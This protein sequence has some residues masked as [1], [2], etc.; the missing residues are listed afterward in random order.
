MTFNEFAYFAYIVLA[1]ITAMVLAG[2]AVFVWPHRRMA[3]VPYLLASIVL[4]ILSAISNTIEL[5]AA[6]P[7]GTL[8][9]S[10]VTYTF[11]ALFPPT[12]FL[13]TLE[14]VRPRLY[15]WLH[16]K[17]PL[18]YLIPSI[19]V[20]LAYWPESGLLWRGYEMNSYYGLLAIDVQGYGP[21]FW[22]H[23]AYAY[24]ITLFGWGLLAHDYFRRRN[25]PHRSSRLILGGS[26]FALVANFLYLLRLLP[27]TKDYTIIFSGISLL[28]ISLGLMRERIFSLRPLAALTIADNLQDGILL[29]DEHEVIIDANQAAADIL[30]LTAEDMLGQEAQAIVGHCEANG[31]IREVLFHADSDT[32][33]H[34]EVQ[35]LPVTSR[36]GDRIGSVIVL[37]D[38]STRK[39]YEQMLIAHVERINNLYNASAALLRNTDLDDVLHVMVQKARY[40][41]KD[42]QRT[43]WYPLLNSL[44]QTEI[45]SP[46]G[47]EVP[48]LN[49]SHA[50]SNQ[51]LPARWIEGHDRT[52]YLQPIQ[53]SS[54]VFGVLAFEWPPDHSLTPED[55]KIIDSYAITAAAAL[56][57]ALYHTAI[58]QAELTDP[59]TGVLNR[60]GLYQLAQKRVFETLGQEYALLH[61]DLDNLGRINQLYGRAAGDLTLKTVGDIIQKSLRSGDIVSRYG[62]DDFLIILPRQDLD[63]ARRIANRLQAQVTQTRINHQGST[64][65]ISV[66]IGITPVA[67]NESIEAALERSVQ[68]LRRAKQQGRNRIIVAK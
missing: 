4:L 36:S 3:G 43:I 21:W 55:R 60:Q 56:Q 20:I 10:H 50:E 68:A 62:D 13:F 37:H 49:L 46:A 28:L 42:C 53:T 1:P 51:P 26:L 11:I 38:V 33:L 57:N 15:H 31:E 67:A 23:A 45:A 29:L 6:T 19:T 35:C 7:T 17:Y 25:T 64:F 39:A 27:T 30:R 61:V 58:E 41:L 48:P 63:S 65:F 8:W 47:A 44:P 32:P 54:Q 18:V 14:Y 52:L 9:A 59:L 5:L 24:S 34:C 66:S 16:K 22:I 40:L 12:F 2:L